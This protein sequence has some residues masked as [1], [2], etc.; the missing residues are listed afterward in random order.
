MTAS[1]VVLDAEPRDL[2]DK[3]RESCLN[4][5]Q[6]TDEFEIGLMDSMVAAFWRIRRIW[7]IGTN[8]LNREMAAETRLKDSDATL[9][10][11]LNKNSKDYQCLSLYETRLSREFHRAYA[12]VTT[13]LQTEAKIMEDLS[14]PRSSASIRG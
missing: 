14:Y 8:A 4:R 13:L 9:F 3:Y 1:L 11:A 10:D 12:V 2:F 6:P 7:A 5:F